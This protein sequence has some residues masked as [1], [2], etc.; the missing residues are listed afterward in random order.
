MFEFSFK[1]DWADWYK[2][3]G[4]GIP[5]PEKLTQKLEVEEVAK[6]IV[7]E[8]SPLPKPQ[9]VKK[10][11]SKNGSARLDLIKERASVYMKEGKRFENKTLGVNL[12][13]D[14]RKQFERWIYKNGYKNIGPA[15]HVKHVYEPV[16][17]TEEA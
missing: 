12:L 13:A 5:K 17:E 15:G 9:V 2:L 6:P 8:P 16:T 7:I 10:R 4:Q 1:G 14:E 11:R 3:L